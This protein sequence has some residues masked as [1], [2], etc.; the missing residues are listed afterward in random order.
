MTFDEWRQQQ[1]HLPDFM[2]DFHDQ[3]DLFKALFEVVTEIDDE[4]QKPYYEGLNFQNTHVYVLDVFLWI[5]A[6]HGYTLQKNRSNFEFGDINEFI[7][8]R[9]DERSNRFHEMLQNSINER[10]NEIAAQN[11]NHNKPQ[12]CP[13]CD[14][15][16]R[17]TCSVPECP[18]TH[19]KSPS[20]VKE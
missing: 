3:K 16:E 2:R 14:A 6:A 20:T 17:T 19:L 13:E 9:R 5:L 18:G 12:R 15:I 10:K 8:R 11:N 1:K 4:H 7:S